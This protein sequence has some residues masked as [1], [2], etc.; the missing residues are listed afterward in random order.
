MSTE[1]E[2]FKGLSKAFATILSRPVADGA[3]VVLS[4]RTEL[5]AA[6]EKRKVEEK[7][8]RQLR[9]T[10]RA[11]KEHDGHVK[12]DVLRKDFEK[13]LRKIANKGIVKIFNA[14]REYKEGKSASEKKGVETMPMAKFMDLL[15]AQH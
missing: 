12:V 8:R 7:L 6:D 2:Q 15:K 5:T 13:N 10:R 1:E 9:E 14:V 11:K 3:K 4:E